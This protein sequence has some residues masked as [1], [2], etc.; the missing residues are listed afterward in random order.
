MFLRVV[1]GMIHTSS[2]VAPLPSSVSSASRVSQSH[3]TLSSAW[4]CLTPSGFSASSLAANS[5]AF[6]LASDLGWGYK[7][8]V[9]KYEEKRKERNAEWYAKRKGQKSAFLKACAEA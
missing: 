7:D 3:S 9:Q 2:T 1:R 4:S 6:K 8:I 5:H